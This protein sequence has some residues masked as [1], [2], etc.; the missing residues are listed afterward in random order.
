MDTDGI[1]DGGTLGAG[2]V[3]ESKEISS[4]IEG[5]MF[6][7]VVWAVLMLNGGLAMI[8]NLVTFIFVKVANAV[9]VAITTPFKDLSTIIMSD[10][11]VV[12]RQETPLSVTGFSLAGPGPGHR[13]PTSLTAYYVRLCVVLYTPTDHHLRVYLH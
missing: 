6:P 5:G 8:V 4:S 12:K 11:L 13:P 7:L 9:V 1:R 3:L 2:A 10:S